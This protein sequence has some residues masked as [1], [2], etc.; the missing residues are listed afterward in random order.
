MIIDQVRGE[1]GSGRQ[2]RR[3]PAQNDDEERGVG[4]QSSRRPSSHERARR[5]RVPHP[6]GH[7]AER[8]AL[9]QRRS[10][11]GVPR[12]ADGPLLHEALRRGSE[13]QAGRAA[14]A[15]RLVG[16]QGTTRSRFIKV[17][18]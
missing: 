4:P 2:V 16:Q 1:A 8:H 9:L 7:R 15:R 5:V 17:V 11:V 13:R 18:L 14:A 6:D 12:C 10:S 3:I